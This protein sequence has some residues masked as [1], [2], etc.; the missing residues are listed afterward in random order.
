MLASHLSAPL[1]VQVQRSKREYLTVTPDRLSF[2][3]DA[4]TEPTAILRMEN[5]FPKGEVQ[6]FVGYG[7]EMRFPDAYL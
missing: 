1:P 4:D 5:R 2:T 6:Y 3:L 7:L